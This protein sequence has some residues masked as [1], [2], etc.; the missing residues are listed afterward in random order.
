MRADGNLKPLYDEDEY[1]S[2]EDMRQE[3]I[4]LRLRLA[5]G[6]SDSDYLAR[7]GE[8]FAD[9]YQVDLLRLLR[10]GYMVRENDSL[11]LTPAGMYVSNYILSDLLDFGEEPIMQ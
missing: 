7:F 6:I 8:S 9:R 1:D 3:Y 10:G 4:M 5:E 2:D 11:R